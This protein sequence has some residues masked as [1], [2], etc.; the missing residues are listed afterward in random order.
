[1][2]KRNTLKYGNRARNIQNK[3]VINRDPMTAQIQRM[4]SQIEHLQAQVLL[5]RGEGT[6]APFNELQILKHKVSLLEAS[7]IDLKRELQERRFTSE[8]LAQKALDA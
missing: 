3:A 8:H 7:N 6:A 4:R 2:L 5:Y 1:M